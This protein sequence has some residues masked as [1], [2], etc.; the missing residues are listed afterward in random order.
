[1]RDTWPKI[2]FVP[3]GPY[4]Q[5]FGT[6]KAHGNTAGSAFDFGNGALRCGVYSPL[7]KKIHA[8]FKDST[9]VCFPDSM[10]CR[11]LPTLPLFEEE[12]CN[13]RGT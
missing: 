5:N 11:T 6:P 9:T 8:K 13:G 1:M 10:G 12:V 2:M 4:T 3:Q 7:G